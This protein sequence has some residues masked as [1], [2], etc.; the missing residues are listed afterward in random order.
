MCM[1]FLATVFD[2]TR[3]YVCLHMCTNKTYYI[4]IDRIRDAH[5]IQ[6]KIIADRPKNIRRFSYLYGCTYSR[7]EQY[8]I[9]CYYTA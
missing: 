4:G 2:C 6:N 7:N 9:E 3:V 5:I 8:T 1:A